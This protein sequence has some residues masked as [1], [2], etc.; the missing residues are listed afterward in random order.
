MTDKGKHKPP[1]QP[2]PMDQKP[3]PDKSPFR[4][5]PMHRSKG[6]DDYRPKRKT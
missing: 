4:P 2:Q 5:P 6:S 1:A 3:S